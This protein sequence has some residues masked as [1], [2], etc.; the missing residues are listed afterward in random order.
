MCIHGNLKAAH[1]LRTPAV[2]WNLHHE[3]HHGLVFNNWSCILFWFQASVQGI[4]TKMK[5]IKNKHQLMMIMWAWPAEQ[6]LLCFMFYTA[7][8]LFSS[9]IPGDSACVDP[10]CDA[11]KPAVHNSTHKLWTL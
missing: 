8:N 11:V 5:Y 3:F 7:N 1:S 6:M 4:P 2:V 10:K 9:S